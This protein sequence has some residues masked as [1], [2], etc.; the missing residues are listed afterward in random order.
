MAADAR[1]DVPIAST[2]AASRSAGG[3]EPIS[4]SFGAFLP[5]ACAAR[6]RS[7]A[8]G[9]PS[10]SVA[11]FTAAVTTSSGFFLT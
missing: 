8:I 1:T 11:A 6:N 2:V 3:D 7:A 10:R 9:T 4:M 5:V